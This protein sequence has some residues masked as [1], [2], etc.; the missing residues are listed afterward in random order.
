M[1]TTPPPPPPPPPSYPPSTPPPGSQPPAGPPPSQP[2]YGPP[3]GPGGTPPRRG[4][5]G[6]AI[7]AIIAA[8]LLVG[9]GIAAIVLLGGE[10]K[11]QEQTQGNGDTSPTAQSP[12]SPVGS[13]TPIPTTSGSVG[14]SAP[15]TGTPVA[16][17]DCAA[18]PPESLI[19][20]VPQE[21]EAFTL[22]SWD[23]APQ[24]AET[25]QANS[26]I[27]VEFRRADAQQVLH[28]LF[29]YDTHTAAT[30]A[31]DTY[32]SA[33]EGQG[34]VVQEEGRTRGI[35]FTRLTGS[36]EIIVWSNGLLMGVVE[37]P[38]DI[39]AGFFLSLPY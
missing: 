7:A 1:S 26:A 39:A 5:P 3:S 11:P 8:V 18:A 37:G 28:Y 16:A 13:G 27:E 36:E 20:C 31:K 29:S 24:F 35:N 30:I 21:I 38:F 2:P 4:F 15:P 22:I 14:G 10:D 33:F 23:N 17:A 19:S 34:F 9:G 25:F 12:A 6:W 32:V